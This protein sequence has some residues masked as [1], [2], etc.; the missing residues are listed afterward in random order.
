[1]RAALLALA[2]LAA[3][4]SAQ[5]A[6]TPGAAGAEAVVGAYVEAFATGDFSTAAGALD[7]VEL[8]EFVGL[9]GLLSETDDAP[10]PVDTTA[11]PVEAF[12]GFLEAIVGLAPEMG[13]AFDS[14]QATVLGSVAEGDSLRH[15]VVRSEVRLFD[16]TVSTVEATTARWTGTRWVVTFDAKMQQFRQMLEGALAAEG[17]G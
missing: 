1:M 10:F 13:D 4:A 3:S 9:L 11:A 2:C 6:A 17:D 14:L 5:D 7:P 12:A 16:A 8:G 15:V